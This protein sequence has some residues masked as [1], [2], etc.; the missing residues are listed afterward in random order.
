MHSKRGIYE[1]TPAKS[2]FSGSRDYR[3]PAHRLH[4]GGSRVRWFRFHAAGCTSGR[5]IGS[6]SSATVAHFTLGNPFPT[7]FRSL[8]SRPPLYRPS[9]RPRAFV[10]AGAF[11]TRSF[12]RVVAF[13]GAWLHTGNMIAKSS[14]SL[15]VWLIV[16]A[17]LVGM[18]GIYSV[19]YFMT[20]TG[21]ASVHDVGMCRMSPNRLV[22]TLFTPAALIESTV[23]GR[24]V[25]PA[26]NSPPRK[27]S[28]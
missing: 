10:P 16:F 25:T 22:G 2:D 28:K 7:L 17:L 13:Q 1:R 11:P 24:R 9:T 19:A 6:G 14:S 27:R 21:T 26:W 23:T 4:A 12:S 20:S 5:S 18:A 3:Y 15:T 8:L